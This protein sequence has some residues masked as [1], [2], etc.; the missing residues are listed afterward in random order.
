MIAAFFCL[1]GFLSAGEKLD[2]NGSFGPDLKGGVPSGW[3]P[4][5][6]NNWDESG[7]CELNKISDTERIALQITSK[8]RPMHLFSRKQWPTAEGDKCV[9]MARVK[10]KGKGSLGFYAYPGGKFERKDFN[11]T[12]EW[13]EFI[14]EFSIPKNSPAIDNIRVVIAAS[15][16]ASVEFSDVTA[17]IVK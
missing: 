8:T 12:A 16:D 17:E 7:W 14:A 1:C 5:K 9:I 4:N 2:I 10:G 15:P 11:A 13:T 6:P 3:L